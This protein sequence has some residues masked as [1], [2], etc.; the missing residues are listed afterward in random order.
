MTRVLITG[1]QG[2][3]GRHLHAH[4]RAR[5]DL[6]VGVDRECDVTDEVSVRAVL[7]EVEPEVI[8]HLAAL[9]HVGESWDQ[10][11]EFTRVNVVGTQCLLNAARAVVPEATTLMVSTS[12]VYGLVSEAD[13][14]LTE[15]FRVA[16]LSPYAT[17]KVE[18][19]H[20][21]REAWRHH[22]QRVIIARPFNHL[23]PGQ[24]PNFFV[25]AL[26][27]RLLAARRDGR[28]H[29]VVGDLAPRR[30]VSDVRDVVRAYALL[31]E[32]GAPGE[33]YH[34]ASERD[35]AMRTL[36]EM[37]VELVA[38]GTRLERDE[39]LV[40]PV[41]IPVSRGS[42]AK[43]FATTGWRGEIELAQTLR[44]VVAALEIPD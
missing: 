23:G 19:E 3:V 37:L 2:F 35:V 17:S 21:A 9:T 34:V 6:V 22:D 39:S 31:A 41:E 24:S 44:D 1:A 29:V 15:T 36:A 26:A 32:Y 13:L 27:S 18:A 40:R 25:P 16:P 10:A 4:L 42:A 28:D 7:R 14:P 33:V 30:D 20:V 8:F 11:A 5:G 38:P 43:I 12:E